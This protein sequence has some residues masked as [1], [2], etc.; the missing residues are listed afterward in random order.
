METGEL[1]VAFMQ[2]I[3]VYEKVRKLWVKCIGIAYGKT[4]KL[5]MHQPALL[6]FC[7]FNLKST[8][9]Y[10]NTS[11]PAGACVAAICLH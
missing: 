2:W 1:V 11:H 8:N 6:L 7:T 5:Q 10:E 9:L 4:R 3:F